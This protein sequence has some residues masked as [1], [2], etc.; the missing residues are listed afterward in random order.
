MGRIWLFTTSVPPLIGKRIGDFSLVRQ[1]SDAFMLTFLL[2]FIFFCQI[3]R[4]AHNAA[5]LPF[6]G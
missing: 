1:K 2:F 4:K 3:V 6:L 5:V